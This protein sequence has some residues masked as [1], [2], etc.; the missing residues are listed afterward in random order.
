MKPILFGAIPPLAVLLILAAAIV[1][2]RLR[3]PH[4]DLRRPFAVV[5][6]RTYRDAQRRIQRLR[7]AGDDLHAR[8]LMHAV[9]VWLRREILTG[10]A[11]RRLRYAADL[12]QWELRL[13]ETLPEA[14]Q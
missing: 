5:D 12:E 2:D 14:I 6:R 9:C 13:V 10:R 1:W 7:A 8:Y 4:R 3:E 11:S